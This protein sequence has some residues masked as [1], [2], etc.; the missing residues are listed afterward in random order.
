MITIIT[1][2]QKNTLPSS[3]KFQ[4]SSRKLPWIN[5]EPNKGNK[6]VNESIKEWTQENKRKFGNGV[7]GWI[8]HYIWRTFSL[9]RFFLAAKGSAFDDEVSVYKVAIITRK[10]K[11]RVPLLLRDMKSGIFLLWGDLGF[12]FVLCQ[13]AERIRFICKAN[14][15]SVILVFYVF[16]TFEVKSCN[17]IYGGDEL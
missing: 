2:I 9:M 16:S 10:I 8:E 17:E 15:L 14:F 11:N 12:R 7:R 3:I 1:R 4:V 6:Q 5:Q 13:R